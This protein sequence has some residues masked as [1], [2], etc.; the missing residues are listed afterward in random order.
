MDWQGLRRRPP[1]RH[2][3]QHQRRQLQRRQLQRQQVQRHQRRRRPA[4]QLQHRAHHPCLDLWLQQRLPQCR[5]HL[6]QRGHR[7]ER[8]RPLPGRRPAPVLRRGRRLLRQLHLQGQ[9]LRSRPTPA[10]LLSHIVLLCQHR[11]P[12]DRRR[13]CHARRLRLGRP[14]WLRDRW[15]R[16]HLRRA[17]QVGPAAAALRLSARRQVLRRP[18]Q[19]RLRLQVA[20]Q[21][22]WLACPSS[23]EHHHRAQCSPRRPSRPQALSRPCSTLRP[24]STTMASSSFRRPCLAISASSSSLRSRGWARRRLCRRCKGC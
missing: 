14:R 22:Q 24:L 9:D 3:G 20:L 4:W 6:L 16:H 13:Q 17:R 8:V 15:P 23:L 11:C 2:Q 7:R 1:R 5:Q 18:K 12:V 21:S 10:P 19:A